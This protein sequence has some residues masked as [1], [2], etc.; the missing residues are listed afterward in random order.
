MQKPVA[1]SSAPFVI[2][3]SFYRHNC[4]INSLPIKLTMLG[5]R[6]LQT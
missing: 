3:Y 2:N 6:I 4:V 1:Q 5:L